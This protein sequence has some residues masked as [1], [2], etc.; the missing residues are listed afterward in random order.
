MS[1][2]VRPHR[3]QLTSPRAVPGI[4]QARILEWVA[5]SFSSAWRWKEKVK[6]LSKCPT[7]RDPMDYSPPGSSVHG[8]FQAIALEWGAPTYLT[9]ILFFTTFI[10]MPGFMSFQSVQSHKALWLKSSLI[11]FMLTSCYLEILINTWTKPLNFRF[12]LGTTN[13]VYPTCLHMK[14][15]YFLYY[16]LI[17]TICLPFWNVIFTCVSCSVVSDSLQ[18]HE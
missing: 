18:P 10:C 16:M 2:S 3:R 11:W 4:F 13:D 9:C 14:L 12:S 1:D 15:P 17:F 5:I 6:S 8:T 7:L